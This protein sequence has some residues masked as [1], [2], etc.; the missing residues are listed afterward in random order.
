MISEG[1]SS[2]MSD[3]N[4]QEIAR[5]CAQRY[6]NRPEALLEMLHDL[7]AQFGCV[8]DNAVPTLA[9]ALNLSRADVHGVVSFYHDFHREPGGRHTLRLCRAEACQAMGCETLVEYAQQACGETFGHPASDGSVSLQSVYCLG[10]CALAPA[11][12]LDERLIG[13]LDREKLD[14]VLKQ[15]QETSA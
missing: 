15:C 2:S 13:R 14:R 6:E 12:M 5:Q 9:Q 1:V 4:P 10:N 8:P 7:Q 3:P 11:A